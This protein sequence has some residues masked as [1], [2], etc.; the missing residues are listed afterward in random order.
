MANELKK[1]DNVDKDKLEL[2][3]YSGTG[4]PHKNAVYNL[5]L[6]YKDVYKSAVE[7]KPASKNE[8]SI[9]KKNCKIYHVHKDVV[10]KLLEY[11]KMHKKFFSYFSCDEEDIFEFYDDEKWLRL[12]HKD[13]WVFRYVEES[14]KFTIG[15]ASNLS[16]GEEY[17]F[18]SIMEMLESFISGKTV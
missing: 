15:D 16:F 10:R 2:V 9:F 5:F 1:T 11:Y 17:E 8:L 14:K 12:G 3:K 13:F 18:D 7:I 6:K 4:D